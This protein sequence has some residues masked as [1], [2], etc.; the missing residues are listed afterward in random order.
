ME[1]L[2]FAV[3]LGLIP[4]V[5]AKNKGKSFGLWWSYGAALFIVALP[6]ALI[7]KPDRKGVE[8]RLMSE[9]GRRKCP[10][11]A[12]LVKAEAKPR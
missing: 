3:V 8:R 7:M 5:I 10:Y 9:E 1:W 2:I 6:H 4:A 11:C 12:E